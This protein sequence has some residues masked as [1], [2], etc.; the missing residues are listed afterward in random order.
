MLWYLQHGASLK[1]FTQRAEELGRKFGPLLTMPE[2]EKGDQPFL[3][4][5]LALH[6]ARSYHMSGPNPIAI[7]EIEAYC[8]FLQIGESAEYRRWLLYVVRR[9]DTTYISYQADKKAAALEAAKQQR[10][11][12]AAQAGIR[13]R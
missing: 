10:A 3:E 12:A 2:L 13:R 7:S 8:R 1:A 11:A 6:E 4:A 9:M 5:F